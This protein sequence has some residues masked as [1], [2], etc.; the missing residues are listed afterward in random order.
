MPSAKTLLIC[1]ASEHCKTLVSYLRDKQKIAV[2]VLDEPVQSTVF[3]AGSIKYDAVIIH[4]QS[5]GETGIEIVED[6][7][8]QYPNLPILSIVNKDPVVGIQALE[9]GAF[10]YFLSPLDFLELATTI[11]ELTEQSTIFSQ[12]VQDLQNLLSVDVCLAWQLD[13]KNGMFELV[14]NSGPISSSYYE[15]VK[16][17]IGEE[18]WKN[19][20]LKGKPIIV[21]DISNPDLSPWYQHRQLALDEGWVSLITI[22][23]IYRQRLIG[24]VDSYTT[25][26]TEFIN[27]PQ[28]KSIKQ[29]LRFF[30]DRAA[31]VIR[32]TDLMYRIQ[33]VQKIS[34]AISFTQ[35]EETIVRQVLQQSLRLVGTDIGWIFLLNTNQDV[36]EL[37]DS[38][39]IP[40]H[41]IIHEKIRQKSE[42]VTGW[43]AAHGR[44]IEANEQTPC[45]KPL[46]G[47]T[48]KS[49]IGVPLK[50]GQRTIGVLVAKSLFP[51][52][53]SKD[54]IEILRA[55][56]SQASVAIERARLSR[57]QQKVSQLAVNSDF[58]TLANYTVSALRD[59]T[60]ADVI[61]RQVFRKQDNTP[62]LD[63]VAYKGDVGETFQHSAVLRIDPNTSI[64]AFALSK[65]KPV[66][67]KDIPNDIETP[68]FYYMAE[69]KK[70]NWHSMLCVPLFEQT[71]KHSTLSQI[72][73]LSL[74]SR[75]VDHFTQNDTELVQT[76][77]NQ[78][79]IA[80]QQHERKR[81]LETLHQTS[82]DIVAHTNLDD[83]M[84]ALIERA[85]KLFAGETNKGIG[86]G[87]WECNHKT[88]KA[89]LIY[90]TNKNW[91]GTT[92]KLTES[93]IGRVIETGSAQ[94]INGFPNWRD[95]AAI[96]D[97]MDRLGAIKNL[98]EAPIKKDGIVIAI[99]AITDA[100][101]QRRFSDADIALL[102]SLADMVAIAIQNAQ[103]IKQ[104]QSLK[105]QAESLWQLARE[106]SSQP[107][108]KSL[109]LVIQLAIELSNADFAKL[110]VLNPETSEIEAEYQ[111]PLNTQTRTPKRI[112]PQEGLAW[113]VFINKRH[114]VIRSHSDSN[115]GFSLRMDTN[116]I[117]IFIVG[118]DQP[119]QFSEDELR[120]FMT[121]VEQ[122][123]LTIEK[124]RLF[125]Q[126]NRQKKEQIL[127]IH[128]ITKS[129]SGQNGGELKAIFHQMLRW[130]IVLIKG[131]ISG[132]I[133]LL[134]E[135]TNTLIL[136]ASSGNEIPKKLHQ[137][138]L[139]KGVIGK[140]A[141]TGK[142]IILDNV[143]NAQGYL[144]GFPETRSELVVPI[145]KTGKVIGVLNLEHPHV[146]AFTEHDKTLVESVAELA[147]VAGTNQELINELILK[148]TS[149]EQIQ[150]FTDLI[151]MERPRMQTILDL[152]V[153]NA[154][155]IFQ[156]VDCA[157]RL[158]DVEANNFG[159]RITVPS[160]PMTG[161][162]TDPPR[163]DGV[164][165]HVINSKKPYYIDDTHTA[166][167]G[168][169]Q[170]RNKWLMRGIRTVAALPLIREGDVVGVMHLNSNKATAFNEGERQIIELYAKHVA[171]IIYNAQLNEQIEKNREAEIE[172][173]S[174]I[175]NS[176]SM[177]AHQ[178]RS[179]VLERIIDSIGNLL[180]RFNL[181]DVRLV[182]EANRTELIVAAIKGKRAIGFQPRI[183]IGEG[184]VGWVAANKQPQRIADVTQDPRY[185][186]GLENARSEL[187]VPMLRGSQLIGVLNIEHPEINVFDEND[188]KLAQAI[189]DLAVVA[190]ENAA[191]YANLRD[192]VRG[193]TIHKINNLVGS[194]R[195]RIEL[196]KEK[197]D[198]GTP[199]EKEA[200][201]HHLDNIYKQVTQIMQEAQDYRDNDNVIGV[202]IN[203]ILDQAV[204][205]IKLSG[206][207]ED[208][209]ITLEKDYE[210]NLPLVIINQLRIFDAAFNIMKNGAQAMPNG[211]T[212]SV[213]TSYL[214][215]KNLV[216]IIISDTG[217]GISPENIEKIFLWKF[218]TKHKK[219]MGFGLAQSQKFINEIGGDISVAS[220]LGIGSKFTVRL[221]VAI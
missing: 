85:A 136:V 197:S 187:V 12:I 165:W 127:A 115:I 167:L 118:C 179:R 193:E 52:H 58:Q 151:L 6:I 184:I 146:M 13:R 214:T 97:K 36:L 150:R 78:L 57:H 77:A 94:Y 82:L 140:V 2:D 135:N 216:E 61:M 196:I 76:F 26:P 192:N 149:L 111:W 113:E 79:V 27:N 8:H 44:A 43:V 210:Y 208:N 117:G 70:Q 66:I 17:N 189:A 181:Y 180:G 50:K 103:F 122:S 19:Q 89:T 68:K 157:I 218:T 34:D 154:A 132:S 183:K 137:I 22:P 159:R 1:S 171:V 131:T 195:P 83:L 152:I 35:D 109:P 217:I 128:E 5:L 60:G 169:P 114:N 215:S 124:E 139:T 15:T 144:Q 75:E 176:I 142:S 161:H 90:S 198:L 93:L 162:E 59:L 46:F 125:R 20:F 64:N 172:V 39:G 148:A 101:G 63:I 40:D 130:L 174:N 56:A 72:G 29:I 175:A 182:N 207:L 164:S 100:S 209:N 199:I 95:H 106:T 18:I 186:P 25:Q 108:F 219:G 119:H 163:D 49:E 203:E 87:F 168:Q 153:S 173:I 102:E 134:E 92:I 123:A 204:D 9:R 86:V 201:Y 37:Y 188:E 121:L 155:S 133:Y 73:T 191:L 145:V 160:S 194:I 30:A 21:S 42:G 206:L 11:H 116:L 16:L 53:F 126:V 91:Q 177:N 178:G 120:L 38:I 23:L 51:N 65:R 105:Y 202:N 190:I 3:A 213:R 10:T 112:T 48:V 129:I 212:L 98:I 200:L 33:A 67:R 14:A 4:H 185:I 107:T 158:Y 138:P 104:E 55:L 28:W 24:I 147:V 81:T 166:S 54:D 69:A 84:V 74:Y 211:G 220:E 110:Y 47:L 156:E 205:Q 71:K 62:I 31:E 88:N 96:F 41:L 7:S 80:F 170:L 143:L 99:L 45:H 32:Q 221:P 141:Q